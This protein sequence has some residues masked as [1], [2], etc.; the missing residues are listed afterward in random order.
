MKTDL[1]PILAELPADKALQLTDAYKD[2]KTQA[3]GWMTKAREIK[4]TDVSQVKEMKLARDS[5]LALV[6]VRG[7][8]E[9]LRLSLVADA[10]KYT[11]GVDS[12]ARAIREESEAVEAVLFD[13]ENFA[14]RQEEIRKAALRESRGKV[15]TEM[16]VNP[17][18]YQ[19][20][21]MTEPDWQQLHA[22]LV[23][24]KE[25]ARVAALE[26]AKKQAE[27]LAE[28]QRIAAEN[29]RLRREAAAAKAEADRLAKAAADKLAAEQAKA[30]AEAARLAAESAR[31]LAE[32]RQK[33][34]KS[35]AAVEADLARVL[36]IER[37]KSAEIQAQLQAE[38]QA[39]LQ[40]EIKRKADEM[41]EAER[42]AME[43]EAERQ[44]IASAGDAEKLTRFMD[45][46][47]S[48]E[49]PHLTGKYKAAVDYA[50][51]VL[52][53]LELDVARMVK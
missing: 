22:W 46:L 13:A 44:R 26:L 5:R 32:E 11:A 48:I 4:V 27:E 35:Q 17:A 50:V 25:Q 23:A 51:A 7:M 14:V 34:A 8:V 49:V 41:R 18:M 30:R 10:K 20:G 33:A 40:A 42:I 9:R 28:R 2:L 24:A 16:G 47:N 43:H 21:E 52:M 12:Y 19:L 15:L 39:K 6:K 53:K 36:D 38:R 1:T 3:D 37:R 45:A 29:E 31:V